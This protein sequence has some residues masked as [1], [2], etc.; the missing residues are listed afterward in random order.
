MRKADFRYETELGVRSLAWLELGNSPPLRAKLEP[1]A[2]S[3]HSQ[4]RHYRAP[5]ARPSSWPSFPGSW[6]WP[7]P[8]SMCTT[9]WWTRSWPKGYIDRV[10]RIQTDTEYR[11]ERPRDRPTNLRTKDAD[12]TYHLLEPRIHVYPYCILITFVYV[13]SLNQNLAEKCC[14]E[15]PS[16]NLAH[17]QTY[18][19]S[20]TG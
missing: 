8:R 4:H 2:K 17:L 1:R 18:K 10:P 15:C 16:W 12:T 3:H 11:T 5:A 14:G 7:V 6:S 13:S 20:K 19:T 9:S